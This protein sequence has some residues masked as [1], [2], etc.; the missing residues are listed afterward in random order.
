MARKDQIHLMAK[1][2]RMYYTQSMRQVQITE[3]LSIH[4]STVSRLLKKAQAMGMVRTSVVTPPGV[5]PEMEDALEARFDLHQAVVV[6]CVS[7]NEGQVARDLGSAAAHLV[8]SSVQAGQVIGISSWSS[9]LLEMINNMQPAKIGSGTT[10]VQILGGLGDHTAQMHATFLTQRLAGLLG[11]TPILLPAPGITRSA[12]ARRVL[13]REEYVRE[14]VELFDKIDTIL[15]GIGSLEP[16]PLLASRGNTFT[17]EELTQLAKKGAVGDICL[18]Y[19]DRKGN[20]IESPLFD[21]I[22]GIKA[23]QIKRTKRVI[24]VAG[25][26][27]KLAAIQGVL[28]GRWVNVLVIDRKTA[29]SILESPE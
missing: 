18:R 21:R 6:D 3:R 9:A 5:Y 25:G 4:Q 19:F 27:R 17:K 28:R 7:T 12:E 29:Q 11:G 26:N 16:S 10:V 23:S 22:I 13:L 24:A 14:A 2:A 15:V 20:M 1:I 8:E